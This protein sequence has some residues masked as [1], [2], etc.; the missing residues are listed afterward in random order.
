MTESTIIILIDDKLKDL[1]II[2]NKLILDRFWI[3]E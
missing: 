3:N 2:M 1:M